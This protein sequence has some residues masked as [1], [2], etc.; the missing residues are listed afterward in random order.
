M[1]LGFEAAKWKGVVINLMHFG[2][3]CRCILMNLKTAFQCSSHTVPMA[4]SICYLQEIIFDWFLAKNMDSEHSTIPSL[5]WIRYQFL[6]RNPN[7]T[8][9][10]HYTGRFSIK[11]GVQFKSHPGQCTI[12]VC[13]V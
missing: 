2:V 13:Y 7:S 11:F 4:I 3:S 10:L 1:I 5:E 6:P 8:S 9:A 12:A